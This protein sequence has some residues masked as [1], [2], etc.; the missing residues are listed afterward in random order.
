MFIKVRFE[1]SPLGT[2]GGLDAH[3]R[4]AEIALDLGLQILDAQEQVHRGGDLEVPVKLWPIGGNQLES[5]RRR[6][7]ERPGG[8]RGGG[9]IVLVGK[10]ERA[11]Q[12]QHDP[13]PV[14]KVCQFGV[15]EAAA[16]SEAK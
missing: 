5:A 3:V 8:G 10:V 13:R 6:C 1:R 4:V 16:G 11:R 15:A 7:L 2:A 12:V 14:I 9:E